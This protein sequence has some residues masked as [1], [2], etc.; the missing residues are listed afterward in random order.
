MSDRKW[1]GLCDGGPWDGKQFEHYNRVVLIPIRLQGSMTI[2]DGY[3]EFEAG[4]WKWRVY[5]NDA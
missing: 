4:L 1:T 3:Y 2:H 5:E